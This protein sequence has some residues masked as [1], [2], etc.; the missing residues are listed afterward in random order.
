[1]IGRYCDSDHFLSYHTHTLVRKKP[2]QGRRLRL[3][4][5]I[6]ALGLMPSWEIFRNHSFL[7]ED[8]LQENAIS[9]RTNQGD[10][11]MGFSGCHR[12]TSGHFS[13]QLGHQM[14]LQQDLDKGVDWVAPE[15]FLRDP[16]A[17]LSF[18]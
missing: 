11:C 15:T 18:F 7:Q 9:R 12:Q 1:M 13:V 10:E 6:G 14:W 3:P 4:L 16:A 5:M 2:D 17:T 8:K